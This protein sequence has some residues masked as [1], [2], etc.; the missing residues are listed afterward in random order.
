MSREVSINN[1]RKSLNWATKPLKTHISPLFLIIIL[2][3]ITNT[4]THAQPSSTLTLTVT[5]NQ[6]AYYRK[7]NATICANLT[8]NEIQVLD[9]IV[10][11]EVK[12]PSTQTLIIRTATTETPPSATPYVRILSIIPCNSLG[13][14]QESF[15][16]GTLAYFKSTIKNYDIEPREILITVNT[17]DRNSMPFSLAGLRT[18]IEGQTTSSV[19]LPIPI[20]EDAPLGNSTAYGNAYTDWPSLNGWPYCI[21]V[22]TTFTIVSAGSLSFT[23]IPEQQNLFSA[24]LQING[25]YNITFQIGPKAPAGNYTIYATSRYLGEETYNST[26]FR[27]RLLADFDDDLDVDGVDLR[28]FCKGYATGDLKCDLDYD[29][30]VDGLDLRIFCKCYSESP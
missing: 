9:G 15:E 4:I 10:A 28:I 7:E 11:I 20:P 8:Q 14:P 26:K 21:E 22:S 12:D 3:V 16:R 29:G 6:P 25:N 24:N 17:F 23:T 19:I 27:V 18:T 5:T 2:S 13:N 30:D 1:P